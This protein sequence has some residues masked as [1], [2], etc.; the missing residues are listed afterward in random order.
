MAE[1]Q[2]QFNKFHDIIKIDFDDNKP[3]RDKRDVIV[4]NL[5][6]GLKKQFP[7]NTPTFKDFVQG[8]YDLSTGVLPIGVED[9]DIDVGIIFNF[10]K[11]IYQPVQVKEWV[12]NALNT[13]ART[14]QIKRPCVRVQ[15]HQ[16]GQKWFH[17]D[18][19]IYSLDKDFWGN[20]INHIAKGFSGS[21]QDKKIWELSEPFKLKELLK[22]KFSDNT[23]REQ[24]RRIIRYLKRWKDY[25][26]SLI[27]DGKPTG[28][29][30]TA[31]CYNLF[32]VEKSQAYNSI[33]NSYSYKYN[34]LRALLNVVNGI[35]GM[36]SWSDKISVQLPVQP[37]NN[38]FEKMSDRQMLNFK[39]QLN[40][41]KTILTNATNDVQVT[42]ACMRLRGAFGGD[43][44]TS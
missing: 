28:I 15:Y 12:F 19:A 10:N 8:S 4:S 18:L 29:A 40:D 9:Y 44:P 38:L 36:F 13:G 33:Y 39:N 1:L 23:D 41:F 27:G 26:P 24:F 3:L 37:Y 17:V 22:S 31:C 32:R 35:I 21:S 6:E 7:I 25:N 11:S 20:E 34:D 14:V 5:R 16:N 43:F 2:T 42:T 30:L